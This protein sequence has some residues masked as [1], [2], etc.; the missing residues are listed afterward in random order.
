MTQSKS[1]HDHSEIG[2]RGKARRMAL[3]L[4]TLDVARRLG[5]TRERLYSME[6]YGAASIATIERWARALDMD[7]RE[8]AFGKRI[9]ERIAAPPL[10]GS[11]RIAMRPMNPHPKQP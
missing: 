7:P 4:T 10:N 11:E 1:I 8:L 3:G 6:C 9:D 5:C 2:E